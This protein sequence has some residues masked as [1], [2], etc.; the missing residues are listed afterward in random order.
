MTNP[1]TCHLKSQG[2]DRH[3]PRTEGRDV[4]DLASILKVLPSRLRDLTKK[5]A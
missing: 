4:M 5:G 2:T 3:K 1:K